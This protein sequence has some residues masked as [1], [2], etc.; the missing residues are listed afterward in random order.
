MSPFKALANMDGMAIMVNLDNLEGQSIVFYMETPSKL[1][2][3][4]YVA[5]LIRVMPGLHSTMDKLASTAILDES[6]EG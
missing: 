4:S 6:A 3:L 1:S 5:A 2:R